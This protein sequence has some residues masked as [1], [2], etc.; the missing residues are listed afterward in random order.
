MFEKLVE[1]AGIITAGPVARF[2]SQAQ[3]TPEKALRFFSVVTTAG[4]Q[5]PNENQASTI[6]GSHGSTGTLG[7]RLRH[8]R[9]Q[10]VGA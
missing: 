5:T 4:A 1:H 6:A 10:G 9:G 7:L 8:H 3:G 2:H